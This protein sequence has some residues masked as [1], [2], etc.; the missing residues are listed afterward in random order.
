MN[1]GVFSEYI[2]NN[3]EDKPPTNAPHEKPTANATSLSDTRRLRSLN[4]DPAH[5]NATRVE[6]MIDV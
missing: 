1:L 2:A 6:K 3:R 5:T 4:I